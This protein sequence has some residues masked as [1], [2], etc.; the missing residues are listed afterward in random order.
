MP[1]CAVRLI[2]FVLAVFA[3]SANAQTSVVTQLGYVFPSISRASLD[4]SRASAVKIK[5]SD[6]LKTASLDVALPNR[7][8]RVGSRGT[9]RVEVDSV[10]PASLA[11]GHQALRFDFFNVGDMPAGVILAIELRDS[12]NRVVLRHKSTRGLLYPGS[13]ARQVFDLGSLAAGNYRVTI[14]ADA[15]GDETF[16]GTYS[17]TF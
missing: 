17:V 11:N 13:A 5:G 1:R 6:P 4:S 12:A 9:A 15:G 2:P 3:S 7:K 8:S 14:S 16:G 10:R